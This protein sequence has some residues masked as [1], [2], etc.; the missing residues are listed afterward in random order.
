[1]I[2]PVAAGC[3]PDCAA[4]VAKWSEW[5]RLKTR[6][7]LAILDCSEDYLQVIGRNSRNMVR[8]ADRLYVFRPMVYNDHLAEIDVINASKAVRQGRPMSGWY[9]EPAQPSIPAHLCDTHSDVW[10]GA[11]CCSDDSLAAFARLAR[12]SDELGILVSFLGHAEASA[13]MNGM[14]AY[15]VN[16]A[17]VQRLNY[18]HM[19]SATDTLE[20]FKRRLGFQGVLYA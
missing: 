11:F 4:F 5:W 19:R 15:L 1:M 13:A 17:G 2:A 6:H 20:A 18:L 12:V 10:H 14:V 7:P 8:K 16:T 3:G 9:T